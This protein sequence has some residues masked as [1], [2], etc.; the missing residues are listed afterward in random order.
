MIDYIK[1]NKLYLFN[2]KIVLMEEMEFEFDFILSVILTCANILFFIFFWS[3]VY[4]IETIIDGVGFEKMIVYSVT[5]N[6]ITELFEIEVAQRINGS[7]KSGNIAYLFV[8]PIN[9]KS[10]WLSIDLGITMV[11]LIRCLIPIGLMVIYSIVIKVD[12]SCFQ[13]ILFLFSTVF[14]Y[15]IL[16]KISLAIGLISIWYNE[17]GTIEQLKEIIVLMLS[18]SFVPLWFFPK[19]IQILSNFLPFQYIYQVPLGILIG[20]YTGTEII[21]KIIYQ[22]VWYV[23]LKIISDKMY[24]RACNKISVQ[25]G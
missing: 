15:L 7:V 9:L 14:S 21:A 10:Y 12:I 5:S 13:V 19:W 3:C 16:W 4:G 6:I 20:K 1:R 8:K 11:N 18:G 23:F 2:T 24:S 17:L 25:G 22:I